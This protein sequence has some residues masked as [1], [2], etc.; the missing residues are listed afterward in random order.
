MATTVGIDS[1]DIRDLMIESA[2]RRLGLVNR[3][4]LRRVR[5]AAGLSTRGS[6]AGFRMRRLRAAAFGDRRDGLSPHPHAVAQMVCGGMADRA[7][8]ARRRLC[9]WRANWRCAT[10]R[11]G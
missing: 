11:P 2:E 10:T 9:S 1:G 3:V 4:D 8:Q 7:R 6:T 5:R